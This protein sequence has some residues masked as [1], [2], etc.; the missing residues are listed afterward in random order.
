MEPQTRQA[1]ISEGPGL[2]EMKKDGAN[3]SGQIGADL[4]LITTLEELFALL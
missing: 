4:A 1:H 2:I 3:P